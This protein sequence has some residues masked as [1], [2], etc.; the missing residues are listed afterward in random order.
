MAA[1]SHNKLPTH[2]GGTSG[3]GIRPGFDPA[4]L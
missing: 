2:R 3:T 4:S 1:E